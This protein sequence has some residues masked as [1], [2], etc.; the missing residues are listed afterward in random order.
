MKY[1][2]YQYANWKFAMLLI[3][4]CD[5]EKILAA[6]CHLFFT[7]VAASKA[8]IPVYIFITPITESVIIFVLLYRNFNSLCYMDPKNIFEM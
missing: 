5:A 3:E 8:L 6:V 1:N 2:R 4:Y 7:V